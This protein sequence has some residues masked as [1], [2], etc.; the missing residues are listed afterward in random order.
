MHPY[1]YTVLRDWQ[2][3]GKLDP[4]VDRFGKILGYCNGQ[5]DNKRQ[6]L[7][8]TEISN[9]P[10]KERIPVIG[11]V[12]EQYVM[13]D[14]KKYVDQGYETETQGDPDYQPDL[15]PLFV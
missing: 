2:M 10:E 15:D 9:A 11:C 6:K 5:S 13:T 1:Q 12:N 3:E 4:L 7:E 14:F 8:D